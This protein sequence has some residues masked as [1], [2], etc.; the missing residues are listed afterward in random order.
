ML[1]NNKFNWWMGVVEDRNDPQKLGRVRV[2]II[3]IHSDDKEIL[4]TSD[5][6]WAIPMQPTTSAGVSGIGS[7]P[8]GLLQGTWCVGFFIDSDDMQ[9]P[10]VMGTLGGIPSATTICQQQATEA[11]QNPPNSVKDSTGQPVLD[12]ENQPIEKQQEQTT[13]NDAITSTLP[14]LTEEQIQSLMNAIGFKESS[15]VAG[16]VQ[17]YT[18]T[19]QFNYIGKY[20]FGAP[21]L[22]TLGY[23][24]IPVGSKLSNSVLNNPANWT[25]KDNIKSKEDFFRFEKVQESIM[26]QNLK[27]N[28][29]VLKNKGVI[30]ANDLPEKV[31][32]LLAVSHLLGAGGA[33]SFASGRDTKDGNGTTGATYYSLGARAVG[34]SVPVLNNEETQIPSNSNP[35]G[36]LN[37]PIA[38]NPP[39]FSDPNNE[40][41]KCDYVTT[42]TADTNKLAQ[43]TT[44]KTAIEKRSKN[45]TENI[46]T[47]LSGWDEPPPAYCATYPYNQTFE[48]E[49]GHL[50]EF[51]NTPGQER[52]H[53]FHKA[54]T[55]IE[56]DVNGTM[57][58]KTVGDNYEIIENNNYLYCRGK[59]TLTV[60]GATQILV[61]NNV[62]L[63]VYGKTNATF[64]N[65]LNMNVAGDMNLN[66]GGDIKIKSASFL[67]DTENEFN[68][69]TGGGIGFTAAGDFNMVAQNTS[70]DGGLINLNS[71]IAESVE[72]NG[73]GDAPTVKELEATTTNDLKRSDCSPDAFTLDAGEPGAAQIHAAQVARGEVVPTTPT[74]SGEAEVSQTSDQKVSSDC[75]EFASF[76]EFPDTIKL[77]KY[78]TLGQLSSRA[79]V[80]KEKVV[81]QRGLS[82]PQI[83]CNLKNLSVNCLDRIKDKYP[84]MIVTNAFRL[85]K[86]GR[87]SADHGT[88]MAADIQFTKVTASDYFAIVQWIAENIPFKQLLLEYGGGARMPW[89]HIAF[90]ISGQKAALPYATF[91]D[92]AV[93]AR[94]K[95]VN[96]A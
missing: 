37:L 68:A 7:A 70:I 26:F 51:D 30:T 62:D 15:S 6:P 84:D 25:G 81:S 79:I 33:S 88:G 4:S 92:H 56:I 22:A 91:K 94:N 66:V 16:G 29:G 47:V 75:S 96:L 50:V 58:R 17:N 52:I 35:A 89:I 61:K 83:V 77:S 65:D 40:F 76:N 14:P 80:V 95:F 41:P 54:G 64:N 10:I 85:D 78:F 2:R 87:S 48:T 8:V 63:Q 24:K 19:N 42:G 59:Y 23:V 31:A 49:S 44:E 27:F 1:V 73:L 5:L 3:G 53:V 13:N 28:Y 72:S 93:Y 67:L 38:G 20:Q 71:G 36:P 90:D 57:V 34:T 45:L 32:G 39:A 12:A 43:G 82:V 46:D 9:Q 21:A 18:A 74:E 60:E 11:A 69:F 86:P 55:Y